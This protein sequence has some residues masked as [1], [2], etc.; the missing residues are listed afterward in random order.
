[1]SRVTQD[2]CPIAIAVSPDERKRRAVDGNPSKRACYRRSGESRSH[3][4]NPH[5]AV[6]APSRQ[7]VRRSA[8]TPPRY[9]QEPKSPASHNRPHRATRPRETSHDP[10]P[11]RSTATKTRPSPDRRVSS[12]LGGQAAPV[13]RSIAS[14]FKNFRYMIAGRDFRRQENFCRV[15]RAS[16]ENYLWIQGLS[17]CWR[18]RFLVGER[19]LQ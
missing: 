19:N 1:M 8:P 4:L 17:S 18:G 11:R 3:P 10:A 5:Y 6:R 12:N 13:T 7:S 16:G 2:V 15:G 14:S 9:R